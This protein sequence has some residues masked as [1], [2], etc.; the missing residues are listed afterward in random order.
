MIFASRERILVVIAAAHADQL[1]HLVVIRLDV[2]V[3]YGPRNLPSIALGSGEIDIRIAQGN[4]APYVGF[5]AAAPHANQF[6]RLFGWRFV[7][8]F[9]VTQVEF[10]RMLSFVEPLGDLPWLYV[11]PNLARL[12]FS[13]RRAG[14]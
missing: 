5:A 7:R 1:V 8:L 3:T 4:A 12:N 10:G 9:L 6:E 14:R 13:L 2:L 11:G